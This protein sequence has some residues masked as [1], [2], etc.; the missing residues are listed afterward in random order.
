MSDKCV[1]GAVGE[2]P[3]ASLGTGLQEA[4]AAISPS[5]TTACM[6]CFKLAVSNAAALQSL[7]AATPAPQPTAAVPTTVATEPTPET[8]SDEDTGFATLAT[9]PFHTAKLQARRLELLMVISC[10][11]QVTTIVMIVH[12]KVAKPS[13]GSTMT[14]ML[15]VG[16]S[17][18]GIYEH[19]THS[20]YMQGTA[21]H[22]PLAITLKLQ[23]L[24]A[25]NCLQRA[26]ALMREAFPGDPLVSKMTARWVTNWAQR[27]RPPPPSTKAA[28]EGWINNLALETHGRNDQYCFLHNFKEDGS[29]FVACLSTPNLIRNA[30]RG[31]GEDYLSIDGQFSITVEG[32]TMQIVGTCD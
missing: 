5:T 15:A 16:W 27:R 13:D 22:L 6:G 9:Q 23:D 14:T 8:P 26:L 4:F 30:R 12:I 32:F 29:C 28:L 24:L 7:S 25:G 21:L 2:L 1:C 3:I 10:L 31:H 11:D 18:V 19:A 20:A 17:K